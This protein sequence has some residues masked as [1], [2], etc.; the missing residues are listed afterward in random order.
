M[1]KCYAPQIVSCHAVLPIL[2]LFDLQF[3]KVCLHFSYVLF[4]SLFSFLAC[5]NP[6]HVILTLPFVPFVASY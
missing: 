1:T 6:R 2:R 3:C 4:R 5:Q